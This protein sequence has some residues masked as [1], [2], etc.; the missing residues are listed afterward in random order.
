MPKVQP[1]LCYSGV[2]GL[3]LSSC[4]S[5]LPLGFCS[6]TTS[7]HW[8]SVPF[9]QT[10]THHGDANDYKSGHGKLTAFALPVPDNVQLLVFFVGLWVLV[11][12]T[13]RL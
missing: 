13:L 1:N 10:H 11:I 7:S 12:L 3:L 9:Q 8:L 5:D 6:F 4:T 2:A